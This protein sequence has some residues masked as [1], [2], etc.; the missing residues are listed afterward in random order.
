[1]L[2]FLERPSSLNENFPL[3][4]MLHGYGSDE[5]DLFSFASELPSEY[6]IVSLK[7]PYR[8]EP[9][10]NAWYAINFDSDKGKWNNIPQA[11]E[12]IELVVNFIQNFTNERSVDK[13]NI[14]LIG[15]SQGTI[16]S[17]ALALNYPHLVKNIIG[18]SGYF[19][20]EMVNNLK[21][22]DEYKHINC[23]ASHGT[24]DQVIPIDW[25]ELSYEK[26]L[27]Q[28]INISFKTY[29]IGHGVSPQNFYD[30]KNWL[31]AH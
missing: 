28:G 29:P 26:L 12:S 7:A 24:Q 19:D 25:G 6:H 27:Q 9:Y 22:S 17:Y 16:L 13:S 14:T 1:M 8:L 5:N 11:I 2:E 23:F 31:I 10:G 18:L 4:L 15:F 20:Q 21:S 30:L 3:L